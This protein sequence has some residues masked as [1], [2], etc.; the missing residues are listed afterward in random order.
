MQ[1]TE[2]DA[3]NVLQSF[4]QVLDPS[5]VNPQFLSKIPVFLEWVC[6][7]S[8]H[9]DSAVQQAS[10]RTVAKMIICADRHRLDIA[11]SHAEAWEKAKTTLETCVEQR[12]RE[13]EKEREDEEG[14][15]SSSSG[16]GASA[17]D[18]ILRRGLAV[19]NGQTQRD[20]VASSSSDKQR[21]PEG[22]ISD[23][24]RGSDG[25]RSVEQEEAKQEDKG[26]KE[27]VS[28]YPDEGGKEKEKD[29]GRE[30]EDEEE[31]SPPSS[32]QYLGYDHGERSGDA[33][34][35]PAHTPSRPSASP[36]SGPDYWKEGM[37][38]G[39]AGPATATGVT[40][41]VPMGVR[42]AFAP[43][44]AMFAGSRHLGAFALMPHGDSDKTK[45]DAAASRLA[46]ERE[47]KKKMKDEA[48]QKRK[49]DKLTNIFSNVSNFKF[50]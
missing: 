50:W 46:A 49:E 47:R 23:V 3:L 40:S 2:V 7:L 32:F 42:S 9:P 39:P 5:T 27:D 20:S 24:R 29:R 36:S 4:E 13:K 30:E 19:L 43:T 22:G 34:E 45:E 48:M 31:T 8:N 16:S 12:E 10:A 6:E 38:G 26:K 33:Y 28:A 41:G 25:A 44:T 15:S 17:L 1:K 14:G 21:V 11:S 18:Q 37:Q 35:V